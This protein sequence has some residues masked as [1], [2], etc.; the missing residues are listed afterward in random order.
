MHRFLSV[1][2]APAA[3]VLLAGCGL[4]SGEETAQSAAPASAEASSSQN[5][6]NG[7]TASD[8]N[9]DPADTTND[10]STEAGSDE[11][12]SDT[13]NSPSDDEGTPSSDGASPSDEAGDPPIEGATTDVVSVWVDDSWTIE[14]VDEDLCATGAEHSDFSDDGYLFTC[15]PTA[16]SALACNVEENGST[17]VCIRNAA[18]KQALRFESPSIAAEGPPAPD[19]GSPTVPLHVTLPDGNVC[20]VMS[21][22]QGA[23][24]GGKA[25]WYG[26]DDGSELLTDEDILDTF[27]RDDETWTVQLSVEGGEPIETPVIEAVFAGEE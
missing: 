17:V 22:D 1:L 6:S 7:A 13:E 5:T 16:M 3:F 11:S 23:H 19:G 10:D 15:G 18:D 21:H 24:W 25:S 12:S 27:D 8:E 14:Q 2:A 26:C 20:Y 4:A 9:S